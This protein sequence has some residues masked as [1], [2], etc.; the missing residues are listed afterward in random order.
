MRKKVNPSGRSTES[1]CM[2][3]QNIDSKNLKAR[4]GAIKGGRIN[5]RSQNVTIHFVLIEETN[6]EG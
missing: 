2:C 3:T 1:E 4:T 5:A 6:Q